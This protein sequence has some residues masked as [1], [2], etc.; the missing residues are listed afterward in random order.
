MLRDIKLKC[1]LILLNFAFNSSSFSVL[2][3]VAKILTPFT[4]SFSTIE[5]PMPPDAPVIIMFLFFIATH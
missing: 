2:V 5:L 1:I 3:P 4:Y